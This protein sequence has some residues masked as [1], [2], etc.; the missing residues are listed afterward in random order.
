MTTPRH[1]IDLSNDQALP[2]KQQRFILIEDFSKK[3]VLEC[4]YKDEYSQFHSSIK[5]RMN[6]IELIF[7]FILMTVRLY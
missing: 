3:K 2:G 7:N 4:F 5:D 1:S 6:V